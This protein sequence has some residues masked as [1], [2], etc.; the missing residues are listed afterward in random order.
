MPSDSHRWS[1]VLPTGAEQKPGHQ[2]GWYGT[3]GKRER[4]WTVIEPIT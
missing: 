2:Q 3:L 1:P 4:T